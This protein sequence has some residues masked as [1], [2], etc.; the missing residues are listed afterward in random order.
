MPYAQFV[1]YLKV[2]GVAGTN[3][4]NATGNDDEIPQVDRRIFHLLLNQVTD[5]AIYH[6]QRS[7][8]GMG[9]R[10]FRSLP[11]EAGEA[12]AEK[13][14]DHGLAFAVLRFPSLQRRPPRLRHRRLGRLFSPR[15]PR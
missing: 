4:H 3:F 7:D 8:R 10:H 9:L 6:R 15:R 12:G 1:F 14:R 13:V 11:T 5:L 2:K